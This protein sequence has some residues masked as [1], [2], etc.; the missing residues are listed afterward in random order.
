MYRKVDYAKVL[1]EKIAAVS[2]E[3]EFSS[4]IEVAN[5]LLYFPILQ[6]S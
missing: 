6:M 1:K 3:N 4:D 5:T 2:H